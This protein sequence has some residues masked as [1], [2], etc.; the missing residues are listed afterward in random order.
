MFLIGIKTCRGRKK[1]NHLRTDFAGR[2]IRG[3]SCRSGT[4]EF[5]DDDGR[6]LGHQGSLLW[7]LVDGRLAGDV[8]NE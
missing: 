6:S 2:D 3:H 1:K 8:L 4:F 7:L 5:P